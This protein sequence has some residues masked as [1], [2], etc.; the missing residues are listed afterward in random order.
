MGEDERLIITDDILWYLDSSRRDRR[1][2]TPEL[3]LELAADM[4]DA[5]AELRRNRNVQR[6][7]EASNRGSR[8]EQS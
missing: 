4:I 1:A 7:C 6:V 8:R 5:I 2:L 3:R